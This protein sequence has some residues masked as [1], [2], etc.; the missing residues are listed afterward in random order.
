MKK[1]IPEAILA[2]PEDFDKIYDQFL[3]DL[4]DAGVAKLNE[5]VTK[6]VKERVELWSK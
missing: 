4:E 6:M 1:R 2:K 5:E 3:K